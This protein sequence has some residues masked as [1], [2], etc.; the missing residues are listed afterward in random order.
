MLSLIILLNKRDQ[1]NRNVMSYY[2]HL[3]FIF[4][5]TQT[6]N[7]VYKKIMSLKPPNLYY[8]GSR[9]PSQLLKASGLTQKWVRREISNFEYLMQLNTIAGRTYNDLSQYPVFPWVL[10]DYTSP[11]LNLADPSVY[12]DLSKPVGVLNPARVAEVQDR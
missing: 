4:S 10:S 12:R 3:Y 1:A 2:L 11:Q 7:L 5:L 9:S 6:R 8:T